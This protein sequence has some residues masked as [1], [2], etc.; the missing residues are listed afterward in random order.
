[1]RK[2]VAD[3]VKA[4][5]R[6]LDISIDPSD[7]RNKE[8]L[9]KFL[10]DHGYQ[11]IKNINNMKKPYEEFKTKYKKEA[12]Q[13]F[14]VNL[15]DDDLDSKL[16]QLLCDQHQNENPTF[17]WLIQWFERTKAEPQQPTNPSTEADFPEDLMNIET[18]DV[19]LQ[20][21]HQEQFQRYTQSATRNLLHGR[22]D[23]NVSPKGTK[24]IRNHKLQDLYNDDECILLFEPADEERF[25]GCL[26]Q[27]SY[28]TD[29][30]IVKNFDLYTN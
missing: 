26:L 29:Q 18:P 17:G 14:N 6:E 20:Q 23:P 13:H 2:N 10:A 25:R 24:F 21:P 15:P 12:L 4:I 7:E 22:F 9:Y 28:R 5:L 27:I 19:R 11:G 8:T 1:M 16:N 3:R 30:V